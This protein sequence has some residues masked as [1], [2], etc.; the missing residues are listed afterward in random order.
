MEKCKGKDVRLHED[1]NV[2]ICMEC[3]AI[4]IRTRDN[5]YPEIKHR[6]ATPATIR[7]VRPKLRGVL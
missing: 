6:E 2:W 5:P 4:T 1:G 3:G 7:R